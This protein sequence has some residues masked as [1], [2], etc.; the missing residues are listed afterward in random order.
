MDGLV[1]YRGLATAA[2]PLLRVWLGRRRRRGK[3][4]AGR[5]GER[6][7]RAS[8]PRPNGALVW[9]HAAS[10][11]EALSILPLIDR[12]RERAGL[13]LLMTT[14]TVTSARLLAE[15]LPAGVIHQFAPL[16]RPGWVRAFLDHWRPGLALR[17]ESELWPATLA[18]LAARRVPAVLINAR[19]SP[20]AFRLWRRFPSAG[21]RLLAGFALCLAQSAGDA[22][23]LRRLG[24]GAV[25]RPGNIKHAAPPLPADPARLA[26]LRAAAAGRRVWLAASTHPGEEEI[27]AGAHDALRRGRPDALLV[28][29]PRHPERGPALARAL[30]APGREIR[31]ASRGDMLGG[32]ITVADGLGELGLYYRL[33]EAAF[34]G[35]S[36]VPRG[37]QNPL[38]P[39]RLGCAV[40]HGP[41]MENFREIA[42]ELGAA[43][44]A[45]ALAAPEELAAAAAALFDDDGARAAQTAA[46]AAVCAGREAVLDRVADALAPFLD[47]LAPADAAA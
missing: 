24:A 16:D 17:V 2:G 39:A 41:H 43:G 5:L 21:R 9:I 33:A 29:V 1:V 46:A 7:G 6:F 40:I 47:A 10:V 42:A 20:A 44:A 3:E 19:I 38:E 12:L 13:R 36:L 31:L 11:G 22:T 23:R 8:A 35:G 14:G 27:A 32:D 30:A 26:G 45:R 18:A 15:R 37:G 28:V 4:D 25:A 34:V